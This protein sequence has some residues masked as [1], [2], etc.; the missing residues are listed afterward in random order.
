[1]DANKLRALVRE[2][3]ERTLDEELK[4]DS[5]LKFR[6]LVEHRVGH[7]LGEDSYDMTFQAWSDVVQE[8]GEHDIDPEALEFY[9][10]ETAEQIK[11]T[12]V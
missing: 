4:I 8:S 2:E 11:A 1:M 6:R 12:A 7:E 5:H 10:N 3:V 9:L